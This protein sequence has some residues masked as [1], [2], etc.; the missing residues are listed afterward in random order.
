MKLGKKIKLTNLRFNSTYLKN[1]RNSKKFRII[2]SLNNNNSAERLPTLNLNNNSINNSNNNFLYRTQSSFHEIKEKN[3]LK[4]N[5]SENLQVLNLIIESNPNQYNNKKINQKLMA[6]NPLFKRGTEQNLKRPLFSPSTE[7][8]FY[9]YNILYGNNSTNI[10]RTYSPKMKPESSSVNGFNKKMMQDLVENIYIF[11]DDEI[12]ELI[13]AKCKDIGIDFREGMVQ[14][15]KEF[16]NTKCRNRI[17]NLSECYLGINSIKLIANILYTSDRIACLNLTRNNIGDEGIEILVDS[18]K[19][20]VSLI[21]LNITSNS[22][23]YKGG[24]IIF[25]QLCGQQSI[26]DFNISSIEGVNRNRL[27]AAGVKNIEDF[28]KQNKFIEKF[29]ISGN[30][31]KD[32]GFISISKGLNRNDSLLSINLSNN[33]IRNKGFIQGISLITTCNLSSLNIS[34]N[35]ILDE[36]IIKLTDSLSNFPNLCKLN[37]SNCGILFDGFEYLISSLQIYKRLEH[38]NISGNNLKYRH[39]EKVKICFAGFGLRSLNISKCSLE[40][41]SAYSLGVCIAANETIKY[42]NI[43]QN[44]IKD[45]GFQSF[46]EL[47]SNNNVIESFDCS[48]NFITNYTAKEFMSNIRYNHTLKKLNFFDNLLKNDMGEYILDILETNKTLVYINLWYNYIQIKK[49]EEINHILKINSDK[50]KE[51]FIPNLQK[52]ISKLQFKPEMFGSLSR[53]IINK[54]RIQEFLYKKVKEDDKKFSKSLKK[55]KSNLM[56]KIQE[57]ELL[58]KQIIDYQEKVKD[59]NRTLDK[60]QKRLF[61]FED[62]FHEKIEE[63]TKQLKVINDENDLLKAEYNATLKEMNYALM[64]TEEKHKEFQEKLSSAKKFVQFTLKDI[65][66]KK[67]LLE[68]L[69]NPEMLVPIK[70]Q[71][72]KVN[73]KSVRRKS[74]SNISNINNNTNSE[75]NNTRLTTSGTENIINTNS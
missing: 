33:D 28:M 55:E 47:F 74:I 8:T 46:V 72:K 21:A 14:K 15:F 32:G 75:I 10:I 67:I 24:Q 41:E 65:K 68:N 70:E 49:I 42:L 30:S 66:R 18:I 6:I 71:N 53:N 69:N 4:K 57:N 25:S 35:P 48:I 38:L 60:M 2:K 43:S 7:E 22:I 13:R 45:D 29:N 36:G 34:N 61:M 54:R 63:E 17:L 23:S 26:I 20:S 9:K 64:D 37:V 39:F 40:N 5:N 73:N 3:I 44:Q 31:I 50:K 12:N 27:T 62:G 16:C 52:D 1:K 11:N 56:S 51:G 59:I 19:N 58:K